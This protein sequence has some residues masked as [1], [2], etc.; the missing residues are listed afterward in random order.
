[1]IQGITGAFGVR[2]PVSYMM[3]KAVPVSLFKIGLAT[4]CSTAVQIVIFA[5]YFFFNRKRLFDFEED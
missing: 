3:S 5:A 1:M 4:P 2:V